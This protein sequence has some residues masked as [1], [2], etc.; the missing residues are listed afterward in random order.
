M[1]PS[2]PRSVPLLL[3]VGTMAGLPGGAET[4][5]MR[6]SASPSTLEALDRR[7]AT[8]VYRELQV[9]AYEV[10]NPLVLGAEKPI[11][12]A[13]GWRTRGRPETIELL[14]KWVYGRS[15]GRPDSV[16]F[17]RRTSALPD[18]ALLHDLTIAIRH[19][20]K[21]F[22][23]PAAVVTPGGPRRRPVL[24][25]IN[26]RALASADPTRS[27]RD[28]FWPVEEIV[29]RGYAAAVF[30][31]GDVDP[32]DRDPAAR[33][34][35][36]RG[37]WP[38]G[39]G[40]GADSWGTL[41]AW[42]WGASRVLD[43]LE[44]IPGIDAGRVAVVGHS[45]GGKTAL[46]AGA[47]DERF[48]LVVS[49]NSG[50]GGAALSKRIFGE[51]VAAIN[52]GFPH[53]F[54]ANFKQ[55][56]RREDALPVDQHQLLACIAPRG[57]YV[58]SAD[59]DLWADPLGE[60][61]SLRAALPVYRLFGFGR[62]FSNEMPPLDAPTSDRHGSRPGPVGYHVRSGGHNLTPYDWARFMDHAGALWGAGR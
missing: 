58:A 59:T 53:W 17:E 56:D 22:R 12:S 61:P 9:P 34:R 30:R 19:H 4:P 47:E 11:R 54:C 44:Q 25:L 1:N 49:N 31:T 45:R 35:G 37:V 5:A 40:T 39:G 52:R 18:Q 29:R 23:F 42:A 62:G 33:A 8:Y 3:A 46:W 57:L 24:L 27:V 16:T 21:V 55:F 6:W 32:D 7:G 50:C 14:R 2:A 13:A 60:F 28:G 43:C 36:V 51:T 15:P 20:G 41:A 10:R 26:N 38:A 48:G